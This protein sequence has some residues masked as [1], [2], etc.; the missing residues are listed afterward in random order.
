MFSFCDAVVG[1][2]YHHLTDCD[3]DVF[4]GWGERIAAG[5]CFARLELSV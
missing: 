3:V 4:G 1:H 5:K 2:D